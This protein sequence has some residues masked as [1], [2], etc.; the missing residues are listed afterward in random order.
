MSELN[1]IQRLEAVVRAAKEVE[2]AWINC[3]TAPTLDE[4][5]LSAALKLL[6]N[7][8]EEE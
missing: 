7:T 8:A 1:E 5:D 3:S 2:K 4:R 6:N